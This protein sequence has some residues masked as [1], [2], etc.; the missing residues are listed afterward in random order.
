[1]TN[2]EILFVNR[3]L[4]HVDVNILK[5]NE[6]TPFVARKYDKGTHIAECIHQHPEAEV[7]FMPWDSGIMLM[8]GME[9]SFCPGDMFLIPGNTYHH[10]VFNTSGNKGLVVVYFSSG[11][12]DQIPPA[13]FDL[14]AVLASRGA[15]IK[16]EG[17]LDAARLILKLERLLQSAEEGRD[18]LCQGIFLQLMSHFALELRLQYPHLN[19]KKNTLIKKFSKTLDYIHANLSS[20]IDLPELYRRAGL[21]RSRFCEQF[22]ECFGVSAAQYIQTARLEKSKY[23]LV[24]TRLLVNEIA[25]ACGYNWPSFFN[26]VFKKST[27]VSPSEFRQNEK[28]LGENI[29]IQEFIG[30]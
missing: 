1:M 4:P 8:D 12:I 3:K 11:F 30:S 22:K 2:S 9:Q 25:Y 18:I 15:A 13:W 26:R 17:N 20:D 5:G 6:P 27:G 7:C 14:K 23:L 21:S 28:S 24:S 29:K 10:P 16:L 19:Q